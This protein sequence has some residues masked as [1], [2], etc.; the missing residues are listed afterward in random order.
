MYL[1][2]SDPVTITCAAWVAVT[3]NVD[4]FPETIETG[5]AVILIVGRDGVTVT[6]AVAEA[7]PPAP[8]AVA[9]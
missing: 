5:L 4:E 8:L 9:L 1:L 7:C 3:V 2:P 6:I